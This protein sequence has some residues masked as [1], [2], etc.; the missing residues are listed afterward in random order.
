M[1]QIFDK[2]NEQWKEFYLI[3][4]NTD[5]IYQ[6]SLEDLPK[7]VTG[8]YISGFVSYNPVWNYATIEKSRLREV[9][10]K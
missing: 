2:V 9:K 4:I 3:D 8:K 5:E 1:I 10:K 6:S 7:E